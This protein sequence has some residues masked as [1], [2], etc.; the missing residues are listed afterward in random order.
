MRQKIELVDKITP[1]FHLTSGT[2]FVTRSTQIQLC[3]QSCHVMD[4]SRNG[5]AALE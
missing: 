4:R 5:T 3:P 2:G 1:V